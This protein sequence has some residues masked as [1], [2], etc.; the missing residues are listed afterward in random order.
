M[1]ILFPLPRKPV[2]DPEMANLTEPVEDMAM[3]QYMGPLRY[4]KMLMWLQAMAHLTGVA[5]V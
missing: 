1:A 4:Q 5:A 2:G 3:Q